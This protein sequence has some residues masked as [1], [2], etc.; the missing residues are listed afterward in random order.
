MRYSMILVPALMM[1]VSG[2]GKSGVDEKSNSETFKG[3]YRVAKE[4]ETLQT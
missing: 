1:V 3:L 4:V 2:C